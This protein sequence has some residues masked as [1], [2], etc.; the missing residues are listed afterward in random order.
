MIYREYLAAQ[1][2]L[3]QNCSTGTVQCKLTNTYVPPETL[4][5]HSEK[6]VAPTVHK[7]HNTDS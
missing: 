7:N 4:A 5:I 1:C 6:T 2:T 3:P